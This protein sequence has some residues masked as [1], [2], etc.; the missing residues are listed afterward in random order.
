MVFFPFNL[1]LRS[2]LIMI[3]IAL[4]HI[5]ILKSINA[6]YAASGR[7]SRR[8]MVTGQAPSEVPTFFFGSFLLLGWFSYSNERFF[9]KT[10]PNEKVKKAF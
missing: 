1:K 6:F 7:P 10:F 4:T 3:S 2:G 5:Y 9:L 8:L